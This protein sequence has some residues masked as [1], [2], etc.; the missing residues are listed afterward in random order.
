[1]EHGLEE[2]VTCRHRWADRP[3][4][5]QYRHQELPAQHRTSVQ[6]VVTGSILGNQS[7]DSS[8]RF[9]QGILTRPIL[10][11]AI[12]SPKLIP[13]THPLHHSAPRYPATSTSRMPLNTDPLGNTTV[14]LWY[15][16][17]CVC[18]RVWSDGHG[19]RG[20]PGPAPSLDSRAPCQD[21]T[22]GQPQAQHLVFPF[23]V[24]ITFPH[25]HSVIKIKINTVYQC[26]GAGPLLTGSGYFVHWLRLQLL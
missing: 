10:S 21:S 19:W 18:W 3:P 2:F 22:Q 9:P 25:C 16:Q 4:V 26:C 7:A 11:V 20:V 1:M 8:Y 5:H 23:V 15:C 14:M 17:G 24:L 6:C 13:P 12:A